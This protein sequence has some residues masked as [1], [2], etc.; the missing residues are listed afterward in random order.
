MVRLLAGEYNE[1][2]GQHEEVAQWLRECKMKEG[3]TAEGLLEVKWEEFKHFAE[4][5]IESKGVSP[6]G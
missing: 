2:E 5:V 4:K 1:F 3:V 6:S